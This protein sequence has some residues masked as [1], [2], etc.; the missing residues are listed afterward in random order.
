MFGGR[1]MRAQLLCPCQYEST[2]GAPRH[3]S[4]R[5][6]HAHP[7]GQSPHL[8]RPYSKLSPLRV[9]LSHRCLSGPSE[10]SPKSPS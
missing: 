7:S 3:T 5:V 9:M 6:T 1:E 2:P 4:L 10:R 8:L